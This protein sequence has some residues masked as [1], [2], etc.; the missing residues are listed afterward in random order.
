MN[1]KRGNDGSN[2]S[3]A[4]LRERRASYQGPEL[5]VKFAKVKKPKI[6]LPEHDE[7]QLKQY[8]SPIQ[9]QQN[10][11]KSQAFLPVP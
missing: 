5:S 7:I 2:T 6:I 1:F 11:L 4:K 10:P 8:E 3:R 9:S